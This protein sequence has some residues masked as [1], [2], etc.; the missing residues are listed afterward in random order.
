MLYEMF[1]FIFMMN[2]ICH[3][4]IDC[5]FNQICTKHWTVHAG[6]LFLCDPIESQV[7]FVGQDLGFEAIAYVGQTNY[8]PKF[9]TA[10]IKNHP[11]SQ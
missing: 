11:S 3:L 5:T 6:N 8:A 4:I 10:F 1:N 2:T 7:I 9:C